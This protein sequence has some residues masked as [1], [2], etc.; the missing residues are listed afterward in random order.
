MTNIPDTDSSFNPPDT[1][2]A[3]ASFLTRHQQK[4]EDLA[5]KRVYIDMAGELPAGTMLSRIVF[6][7]SPDKQGRSRL[8]AER[9]GQQWLVRSREDWWQEARL[10]PREVDRCL[11]RLRELGLIETRVWKSTREAG[12]RPVPLLHVRIVPE[13]F[14]E[15]M[16]KMSER[17]QPD[18]KSK[19]GY[20]YLLDGPDG[21]YKIGRT[22]RLNQRVL[23]ISLLMPFQPSLLHSIACED[24]GAAEAML[25]ARFAE[26]R[27][28]GEWFRLNASDVTYIKAILTIS[29][30][31]YLNER[32]A[33][34]AQGGPV[35]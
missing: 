3:L 27:V 11:A 17:S 25:H 8:P 6:W 26:V 10:V 35:S 14:M 33:S 16:G 28:N 9:C 21:L 2:I 34:L 15:V 22:K 5:V 23:G 1:V 31:G 7:H 12:G 29:A 19:R 32:V 24:H 20:V 18:A 30:E 4:L 13:V